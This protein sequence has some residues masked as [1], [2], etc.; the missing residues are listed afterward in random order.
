MTMSIDIRHIR[1]LLA[2]AEERNFTRA[3][4]RLG[5]P[6][7]ALSNQLQ[8]IERRLGVQLFSRTTRSVKLTAEGESLLPHLVA[9]NRSMRQIE[10]AVLG[11]YLAVDQPLR[12]GLTMPGAIGVT[13]MLRPDFPDLTF[14][15][16]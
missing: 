4:A 6:Q 7:P 11:R 16:T 5:I 15:I 13:S 1:L 2:L 10:D 12:I 8:R 9:V 3:A 14:D